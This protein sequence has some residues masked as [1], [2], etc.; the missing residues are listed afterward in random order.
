MH[1]NVSETYLM[2]TQ[3]LWQ[4]KYNVGKLWRFVNSKVLPTFNTTVYYWYITVVF[5]LH[6]TLKFSPFSN[7]ALV[8]KNL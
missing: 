4:G 1:F 5:E 8:V 3:A 6:I 7:C 2:T